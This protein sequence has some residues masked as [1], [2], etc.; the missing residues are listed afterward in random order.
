MSAQTIRND[1]IRRWKSLCRRMARLSYQAFILVAGA[2]SQL[3]RALRRL[4]LC[5]ACFR[6]TAV[7]SL[8]TEVCEWLRVIESGVPS[9]PAA[10]LQ[11]CTL[12]CYAR[13]RKIDQREAENPVEEVVGEGD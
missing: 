7:T 5:P 2:V 10:F 6:G 11:I 13:R 4:E 8:C 3:R 12:A 1:R 9:I